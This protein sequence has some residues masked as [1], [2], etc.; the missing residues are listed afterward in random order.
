MKIKN[1]KKA[2]LIAVTALSLTAAGLFGGYTAMADSSTKASC[3]GA[4]S[5]TKTFTVTKGVDL[6]VYV[7]A[8][9]G[10]NNEVQWSVS[11]NVEGGPHCGGKMRV[12]D[13]PFQPT[14]SNY[15]YSI[16]HVTVWDPTM[17]THTY[18]ARAWN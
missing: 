16:A 8:E 13:P 3:V 10:A 14:C 2:G 7:D 15:P 6:H 4:S 5:C 11:P 18:E 17:T 12:D 1:K 9:A